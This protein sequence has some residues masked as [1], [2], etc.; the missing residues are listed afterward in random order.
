MDLSHYSESIRAEILYNH[1]AVAQLP[2]EYV[3]EMVVGRRY[4][5]I[6]KHKNFSPRIIESYLNKKSHHELPPKDYIEAFESSFDSP[7]AVWER[8]F[9]ALETLA[10]YALLIRTTMGG[11]AVF[12][13]DWTKAVKYFIDSNPAVSSIVWNEQSWYN[14]LKVIEGTFILSRPY[15]GDYIVEFHNPS[16]FDFLVGWLNKLPELQSQ[17]IE[18]S[19]FCDQLYRIFSAK[20]YP[21]YWGLHVIK[22]REDHYPIMKN[23]FIRHFET[24][25]VC[26]LNE[27]TSNYSI[28]RSKEYCVDRINALGFFLKIRRTFETMFNEN[29]TL[30]NMVSQQML[31]CSNYSL[32]DRMSIVDTM[33]DEILK[34]YDIESV[35]RIA[36]EHAELLD[37]YINIMSLLQKTELGTQLLKHDKFLKRINDS[38]D[39][40]LYNVSSVEDCERITESVELLVKTFPHYGFE[41]WETA[42]N[43]VQAQYVEEPTDD[44]FPDDMQTHREVDNYE[45]M[46]TSLLCNY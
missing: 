26:G 11:G 25:N 22:L 6:I 7:F 2:I 41:S 43:E 28:K 34:H 16:V 1:L 46:F 5:H 33:P 40:E 23:A 8:T 4:L 21:S 10:Q 29:S 44:D 13:R 45:E 36:V 37:D 17:M 20:D 39:D 31:E 30:Y 27:Y 15:K 42:I 14:C 32:L 19:C 3:R 24:L 18:Y 35:A 9:V 12:M 38:I